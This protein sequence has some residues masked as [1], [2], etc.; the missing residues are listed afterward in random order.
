MPTRAW[1]SPE[2]DPRLSIHLIL[3]TSGV[4]SPKTFRNENLKDPQPG[5]SKEETFLSQ[6][7]DGS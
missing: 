2:I 5:Q 3:A 7:F 4:S 1:L 6:I